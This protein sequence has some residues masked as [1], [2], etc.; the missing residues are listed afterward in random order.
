[1]AGEQGVPCGI[2]QAEQGKAGQI[3]GKAEPQAK[4]RAGYACQSCRKP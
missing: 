3:V 1:M 4:A 2:E